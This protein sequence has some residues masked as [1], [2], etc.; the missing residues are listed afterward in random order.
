M[1]RRMGPVRQFVPLVLLMPIAKSAVGIDGGAVFQVVASEN[2]GMSSATIGLAFGLGVLSLPVQM[3]AAR[4]PLAR[5]KVNVRLFAAALGVLSAVMAVLVLV[6]P[7]SPVTITAITVA[8]TAEVALSVLYATSW[9]PLQNAILASTERQWLSSRVRGIGGLALVAFLLAVATGDAA[10]HIAVF[11]VVAA[12]AIVVTVDLRAMPPPLAPAPIEPGENQGASRRLDRS[13]IW[14]LACSGVLG[15]AAWP[16]FLVYAA[17]VL[18]P[19]ANIGAVAAFQLGGS[20]LATLAWRPASGDLGGRART[21]GAV[22]LASSIAL[23]VVQSPIDG[24]AAATLVIT[25][26]VVSAAALSALQLAIL[27]LMHRTVQQSTAVRVFTVL[28]V[29]ESTSLQLGLLAGGVL[30]TLSSQGARLD[31]YRAG[32]VFSALAGLAL[33]IATTRRRPNAETLRE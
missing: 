17:E 30:T 29:V 12:V 2:L 1:K 25:A 27:E 14:L 32:L 23:C 26:A 4:I 21:S 16:L 19:A 31:V 18:W 8:V 20:L 7:S 9:M 13:A 3:L 5:A 33:V 22:L 10:L 11:V 24:N 28:D 15:F 6:G